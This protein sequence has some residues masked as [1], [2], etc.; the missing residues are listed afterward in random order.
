MATR[1]S[2]NGRPVISEVQPEAAITGGELFIRGSGLAAR[3]RPHVTIGD[4]PA[5]VVVGSSSLVI[6]KV[7]EG[8]SAG[9]LVVENGTQSSEAW[10]CDIGIQI[11]ENLH[12][13]TSPAVDPMGNVYTTFSGT[14]GQK[15]PVAVYRIDLNFNA[16]PFI[17]DMMNATGIA[18]GRDGLVYISSR[19]DGVVYQVTPSGNMSV[20][21][22]GMGVATGL[23]FDDDN[24]LYVGDR[25]G[26]V[27]KIS[28]TRQIF[29]FATIEPSIS[30]YHLA[31]GP[32]QHLYVSGPTTSSFDTIYKVADNG[33]VAPFYRGLG[34]PQGMAF[35]ADGNLY[36]ASSFQGRKGIVRITP[37]KKAD[38]F[39]SGPGIVGL[40]FSPTRAMIVSTTNAIFRVDVRVR[41]SQF[42]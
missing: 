23:V 42:A 40:A 24:N 4:V 39:V 7:P 26:T 41:G 9:E 15:V 34:R 22:E 11:A 29:V 5:P 1:K 6:V 17:N 28:P 2:T 19:F 27:F 33:E 10:T 30:A 18:V 12:P 20:F 21:V 38:L 32:D 8:A 3:N 14:R 25:S 36:S 37:D 31:W 16:T 35:D 13:V